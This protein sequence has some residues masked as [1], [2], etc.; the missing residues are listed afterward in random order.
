MYTEYKT[1]FTSSWS[2]LVY[3]STVDRLAFVL[4]YVIEL[5]VLEYVFDLRTCKYGSLRLHSQRSPALKCCPRLAAASCL[6]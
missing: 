6:F 1:S 4:N 5:S 2:M 3:L